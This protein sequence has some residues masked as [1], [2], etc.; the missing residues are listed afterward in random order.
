MF[1]RGPKGIMKQFSSRKPKQVTVTYASKGYDMFPGCHNKYTCEGDEIDVIC[2]DS[3]DS[4]KIIVAR[5]PG[6]R[7]RF[8]GFGYS[9]ENGQCTYYDFDM[10]EKDIKKM[11]SSMDILTENSW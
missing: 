9:I 2:C 3:R 8:V 6:A 5:R 7:K 1:K 11:L 4:D 10:S